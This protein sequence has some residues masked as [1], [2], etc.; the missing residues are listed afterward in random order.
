MAG[1]VRGIAGA[2]GGKA[3]E[4]VR[5][6]NPTASAHPKMRQQE[7]AHFFERRLR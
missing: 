7:F 2:G 6:L 5:A 4:E 1:Q 3:K